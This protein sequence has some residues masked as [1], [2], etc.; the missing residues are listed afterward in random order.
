MITLV[1]SKRVSVRN[2]LLH[3]LSYVKSIATFALTFFGYII[4][5]LA[6]V[7]PHVPMPTGAPALGQQQERYISDAPHNRENIVPTLLKWK[8]PLQLLQV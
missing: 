2:N 3:S 6:S 4:L 1:Y 7:S 8:L 5:V